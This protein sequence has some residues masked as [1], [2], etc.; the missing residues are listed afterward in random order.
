[1]L[2]AAIQLADIFPGSADNR[3]LGGRGQDMC[4]KTANSGITEFSIHEAFS[5][6]SPLL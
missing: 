6:L 2:S 3:L 1:M 4:H 5:G